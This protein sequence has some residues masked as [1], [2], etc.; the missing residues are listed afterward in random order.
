MD[1]PTGQQQS[2]LLAAGKA[3]EQLKVYIQQLQRAGVDVTSLQAQL[4]K[5]EALKNGL[6]REFGTG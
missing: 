4:N 5:A 2:D 1:V 3:T 6:L